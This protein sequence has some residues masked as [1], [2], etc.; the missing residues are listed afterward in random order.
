M[1]PGAV[2]AEELPRPLFRPN[3]QRPGGSGR[4]FFFVTFVLG[5]VAVPAVSPARLLSRSRVLFPISY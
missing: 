3:R 2:F 4:L 1:A 5:I